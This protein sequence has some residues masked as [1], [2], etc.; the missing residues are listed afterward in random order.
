[1][2]IVDGGYLSWVYG[3][4]AHMRNGWTTSGRRMYS[5]RSGH[6][7][8]IDSSQSFRKDFFFGYKSKRA[9]KRAEN[10]ERRIKHESVKRFQNEVLLEDPSL[11][12]IQFE[13][14]EADDLV[15]LAVHFMDLPIEVVGID[16]DL[17]Q[18]PQNSIYLRRTN[19]TQAT[20]KHFAESLPVTLREFIREPDD[21]LMCLTLMGDKSDS[22][23]RLIPSRRLDLMIRIL[24]REDRRSRFEMA[25]D[26]YGPEFIRNFYVA[27]LPSPWCFETVLSPTD[28]CDI[29]CRYEWDKQGF[30]KDIS[31][32]LQAKI[33]EVKS[34]ERN[35]N[36]RNFEDW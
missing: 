23:P 28:A 36:G 31:E 7:I 6:L 33:Q 30:R 17:L 25:K 14:L 4:D 15:S 3:T 8:M 10:E 35:S 13:G 27:V 9:E 5:A 1:M 19:R 18:L 21:I 20:I 2:K 26:L 29:Y 16:K 34:L 11:S 12:T 32:E 22:I 24:L